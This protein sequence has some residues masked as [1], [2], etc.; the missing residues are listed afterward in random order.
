M[1]IPNVSGLKAV[2]LQ[3]STEAG[4]SSWLIRW[5]S[6]ASVSHVDLVLPDGRL[7]G[8]RLNGGVAI[9]PP[10]YAR[11]TRTLRLSIPTEMAPGI[12]HAAL[13]Q[14]GKPYDRM[15][16]LAFA[17]PALA[18]RRNWRDPSRWICSEL[19]L[20]CFE[21]GGFFAGRRITLPAIK[22]TPGDDLNI[23]EPFARGAPPRP[24]TKTLTRA[25]L[26]GRLSL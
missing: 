20:W 26:D 15:A 10:G 12:Y 22:A 3:F 4:L 13:A 23:L 6:H 14:R 7:L 21:R 18:P 9:R 2:E 1:T 16:I 8:A 5:F 19:V 25:A 11:F 17:L 24:R